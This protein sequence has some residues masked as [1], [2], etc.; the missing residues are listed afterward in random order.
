MGMSRANQQLRRE[1][2]DM[3]RRCDDAAV[4]IWRVAKSLPEE[5]ATALMSAIELLHQNMDRLHLMADQVK[6]GEV[7]SVQPPKP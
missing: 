2:Q 5:H 1:L 7:V 3:E 4:V 6:A